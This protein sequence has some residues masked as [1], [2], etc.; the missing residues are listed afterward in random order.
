MDDIV[1]E[2]TTYYSTE[3]MRIERPKNT[4]KEYTEF[5]LFRDVM[6]SYEDAYISYEEAIEII[7]DG[8]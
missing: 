2:R 1:C 6:M 4:Q 8:L 7:R 3:P 5:E